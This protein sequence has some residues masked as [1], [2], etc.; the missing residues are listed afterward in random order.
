[1]PDASA[2]LWSG[3]AGLI[4]IMLGIIGYLISNGFAGLKTELKTLW[5]KIDAHQSASVKNALAIREINTR[6]E[7]RHKNH[8]RH[9]DDDD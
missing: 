3:I 7:E 1:M 6:C 9:D 5:D 2:I 8:K 4:V